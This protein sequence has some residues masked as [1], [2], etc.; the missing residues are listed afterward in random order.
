MKLFGRKS[1]I[2]SETGKKSL[3]FISWLGSDAALTAFMFGI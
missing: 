1:G 2:K 3:T